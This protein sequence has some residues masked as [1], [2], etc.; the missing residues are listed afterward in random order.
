MIVELNASIHSRLK[1]S[2][3]ALRGTFV[4]RLNLLRANKYEY[5]RRTNFKR[6]RNKQT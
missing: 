5:S 1:E 6:I 3:D 4:L 2:R